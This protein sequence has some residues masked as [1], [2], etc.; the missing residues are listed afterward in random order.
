MMLGS[1]FEEGSAYLPQLLINPNKI[2]EISDDFDVLGPTILM[3]ID[4]HSVTEEDS[5]TAHILR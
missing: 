1:T 5:S 2:E 3:H 4:E